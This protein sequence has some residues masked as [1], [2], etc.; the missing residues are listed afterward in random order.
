MRKLFLDI[1]TLPAHEEN[2]EILKFLFDKKKAK[3]NKKDGCED[4][5]DFEQ[6]LLGT[7][8]DGAY[9]RILCI[10]YAIDDKPVE[11]LN[12]DGDEA[13]MLEKF[14]EIVDSISKPA[15]N[16]QWPDYGVQFI[17]HN[18]MDFDLRF[19]YQ[20]SIVNK[21]KPAYELSFA[22]YRSYPIYDTMK[23]WVKWANNNVGLETLALALGIP[24]PK[25]GID[26]S[27]VYD[28]WKAGKAKEIC[29]Y[30]KRD[31]EC[32]REVYKRMTFY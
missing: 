1:E 16:P 29:E 8:F 30:C 27:Q 6:Y 4:G 3:K 24:T 31:V 21:V 18:V 13:Q 32:T 26:G 19:I 7:S 12:G 9:G 22:R 11:V 25:D 14:W 15:Q 10:A 20:R 23:E 2:H 5:T 17:G 28:F